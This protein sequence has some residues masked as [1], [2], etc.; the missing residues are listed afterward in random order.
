MRTRTHARTDRQQAGR[1]VVQCR[2]EHNLGKGH[3]KHA[4][5][6]PNDSGAREQGGEQRRGGKKM[7][8]KECS[9]AL[10]LGE[11]APSLPKLVLCWSWAS[12]WAGL[13]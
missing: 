7:E 9:V 10:G 2:Q 11:V 4:R 12:G 13:S 1:V 3:R 8:W 5:Q 6:G